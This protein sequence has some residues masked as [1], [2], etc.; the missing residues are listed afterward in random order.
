MAAKLKSTAKL[1]VRGECP[2]HSLTEISVRDTGFKIAE[3]AERVRTNLGTAPTDTALSAFCDFDRRG[4]APQEEIDVPFER[5]A[6]TIR[7][8]S[9]VADKDLGRLADEVAKFCPPSKLLKEAGTIIDQEWL[10]APN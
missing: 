5:V 4:V 8:S 3:Q 7:T 10:S 2:T 9:T 1:S 6:L